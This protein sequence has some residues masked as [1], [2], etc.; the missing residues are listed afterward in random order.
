[1]TIL[2]KFREPNEEWKETTESECLRHTEEAGHWKVGTVLQM[3]SEGR[4]VFTP[5]ADYKAVL[6]EV[7]AS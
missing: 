6:D 1:M 5:W 4:I 3:L 2:K 7:K